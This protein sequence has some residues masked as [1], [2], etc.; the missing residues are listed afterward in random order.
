MYIKRTALLLIYFVFTNFICAQQ[1]IKLYEGKA[2]GSEE[3][4]W[5]K[6][7]SEKNQFN[8]PIVYNVIDPTITAYLPP[9]S[10][11]NGTAV[12]VAPGGAFH[13]LSVQSEGIDV[14]KWLNSKGIAAFVLKYRLAR[15]FTDD[16]VKELMGKMS[17]FDALDKENEPIIPLAMADGLKAMEYVRSN[18]KEMNIDPDKVGFMGFSAGG[19]LA[20]SVLYNA[21]EDTRPNFVAPIYAYEPAVIGSDIPATKTPIY[22]AVASDDQLGMVPYSINIYKKWFEADQPSEL[23]IYEKGGHGFGMR[24]QGIPTD[25]WYEQFGAWLKMHGFMEKPASISPFQR[26]P[27]PNDSLESVVWREDSNLQFNIYAPEAEKVSVSGDFPGGF[28]GITLKKDYLGVWSGQTENKVT[29]D[30]YTYDFKVNEINTLD[31]KNNLVK[32]S[33][34]GFSNLVEIKGPENNFQTRKNVPHGRVEEVWYTS[35]SLNGAQRRLHVYLPPSYGQLKKKD[36]LPVLYLLHGGGD[37]DASWTTAGRANVILDNLYAEGKLE[38]MLVVMPSGHT[39]EEGFFMGVGPDQDPFC[40][41]LLNDI[42]PLIESTYPVSTIRSHRA[43]AG[44]SMGGVQILNTALWNPELFGYVIPMSTGYFSPNIAEIKEKYAD[45]M[46]NEEINQFDL[47]QI[48]MGG[49]EDIAYQ[50]NLNMMAM[51]DDF[52]IEYNYKNGGKGHTFLTWRRNL[53]DFAPLLFKNK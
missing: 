49:E 53:H 31:P 43:I 38:P 23:H 9:K 52:G 13:T 5:K 21:D 44:L 6:G 25:T 4:T 7:L 48:Y 41:D 39:E 45:V 32:E 30:I 8:T 18:A 22:V 19:T 15:S 11:A 20:M 36:K 34:N 35:Q 10:T 14:A 46:K 2:P 26:I 3:W 29:P 28:P 16:P 37:N 27:S 24:Q 1:E 50:N 12:I 40:K 47:F 17:D 51:F 42:I 33:L